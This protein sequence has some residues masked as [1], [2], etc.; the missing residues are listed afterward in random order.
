[1]SPDS[2]PIRLRN[3]RGAMDL[4]EAAARSGISAE[5]IKEYE[6]GT[7]QPYRKTLKRLALAYGVSLA[8]LV[9]P[10]AAGTTAPRLR[11]R[12]VRRRPAQRETATQDTAASAIQV[13]VTIGADNDFRIV[14]EL[15]IRIAADRPEAASGAPTATLEAEP[16]STAQPANPP[17]ANPEPT[18]PPSKVLAASRPTPRIP[19]VATGSRPL[20]SPSASSDGGSDDSGDPLAAVRRA[21]SE[22]RHQRR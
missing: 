10:A 8:E 17:A 22:F 6:S 4:A 18:P 7:R 12:Q 15:V 14:I 1:M 9:G 2:L 20:G 13:P 16:Q 5:R 21:Y 19:A 3:A 11:A